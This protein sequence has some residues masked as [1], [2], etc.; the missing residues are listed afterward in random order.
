ML[1]LTSLAFVMLQVL[2]AWG[3]AL[4]LHKRKWSKQLASV[5]AWCPDHEDDTQFYDDLGMRVSHGLCDKC[6]KQQTE[7]IRMKENTD[8]H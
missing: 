6:L 7:I 5:C 8:D 4:F 3:M 2:V 1:A